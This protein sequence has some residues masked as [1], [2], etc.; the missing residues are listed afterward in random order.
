MP[1][2]ALDQLT[3][4][5]NAVRAASQARA[6]QV[7]WVLGE[8][9][10]VLDNGDLPLEARNSARVLLTTFLE[11]ADAYRPT[12]THGPSPWSA[13]NRRAICRAA[14]LQP[15]VVPRTPTLCR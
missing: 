14:H 8:L 1:H 15:G 9:T 4:A 10:A 7:N 2:P 5:L 12:C 11:H 13:R 6:W 3:P